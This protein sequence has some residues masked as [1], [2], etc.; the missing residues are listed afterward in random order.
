MADG[1]MTM[2]W[3]IAIG[4]VRAL[5]RR[6]LSRLKPS[7]LSKK[8]ITLFYHSPDLDRLDAGGANHKGVR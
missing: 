2:I 5:A 1:S 7:R 4:H 8:M 3:K 6:N